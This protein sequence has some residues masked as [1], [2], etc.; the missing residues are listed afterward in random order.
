MDMP[1]ETRY[2]RKPQ[3]VEND[4][5]FSASLLARSREDEQRNEQ[6]ENETAAT[7]NKQRRIDCRAWT[8]ER[9]LVRAELVSNQQRQPRKQRAKRVE[10]T[11]P[12]SWQRAAR[13]VLR[14]LYAT[15]ATVA[16][17]AQRNLER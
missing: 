15:A 13:V 4:S 16:V 2:A 5:R 9:G 8:T 3:T 11:T 7:T 17:W 10:L 12:N 14:L 1:L 6:T